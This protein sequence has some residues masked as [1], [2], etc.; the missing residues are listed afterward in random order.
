MHGAEGLSKVLGNRAVWGRVGYRGDAFAPAEGTYA[1]VSVTSLNY[2]HRN[3]SGI[4]PLPGPGAAL[5]NLVPLVLAS[6]WDAAFAMEAGP[7]TTWNN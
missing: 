5:A 3:D 2:T 7:L 4:P 1:C 6:M